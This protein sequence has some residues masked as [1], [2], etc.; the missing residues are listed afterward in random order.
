MKDERQRLKQQRQFDRT[1]EPKQCIVCGRWFTKRR[2][3]IC[4]IVCAE[5]AEEGPRKP[6]DS[7]S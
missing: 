6:A 4:S 1:A 2:G 7:F 5:K 3:K